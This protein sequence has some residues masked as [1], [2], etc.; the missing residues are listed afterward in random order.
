MTV[1]GTATETRPWVPES[2]PSAPS[3]VASGVAAA[4]GAAGAVAAASV[5]EVSP[6]TETALPLTVIGTATSSRA[7]VPEP[8][9]S[10][11]SVVA[12]A[13]G[14]ADGV[15]AGVVAEASLEVESPRIGTE[16]PTTVTGRVTSRRA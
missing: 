1:T 12:S 15:A 2:S 7:W 16:L 11:P 14:T 3:V 6:S 9:P 8:T 4:A 13:A 10:V 5:D